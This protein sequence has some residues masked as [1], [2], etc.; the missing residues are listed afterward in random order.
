MEKGY[1][2]VSLS[3]C[4]V[5]ILLVPKKDETWRICVDCRAINI[6]MVKYQHPISRLHDIFDELH[7]TLL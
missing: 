6:I 7:E 3:P 5:S 4:S 2:Q 1:I